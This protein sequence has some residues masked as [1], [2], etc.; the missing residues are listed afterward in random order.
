M[1]LYVGRKCLCVIMSLGDWRVKGGCLR[2]SEVK[3][4]CFAELFRGKFSS[5]GSELIT[6][7]FVVKF[8]IPVE[9]FV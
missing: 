2:I 5:R 6:P 9:N 1:T 3:Q 8:T 7:S 4:K